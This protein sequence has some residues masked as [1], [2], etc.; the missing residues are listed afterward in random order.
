M[1]LWQTGQKFPPCVES[2]ATKTHGAYEVGQEVSSWKEMILWLQS[3]VSVE[4]VVPVVV[5]QDDEGLVERQDDEELRS[6]VAG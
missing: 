4:M 1:N 3:L 6:G 2:A 5:Q